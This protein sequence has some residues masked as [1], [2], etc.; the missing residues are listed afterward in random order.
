MDASFERFTCLFTGYYALPDLLKTPAMAMTPGL[1][2]GS[3][4]TPTAGRQPRF[5][6]INYQLILAGDVMLRLQ[7][8]MLA[9][10]L[11]STKLSLPDG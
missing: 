7:A 10:L 2:N 11:Y 5:G 9:L 6:A 4:S 1:Q 3:V 8:H